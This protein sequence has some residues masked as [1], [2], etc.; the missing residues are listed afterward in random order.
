[1]LFYSS[2]CWICQTILVGLYVQSFK[3]VYILCIMW[4][5]YWEHAHILTYCSGTTA[6]AVTVGWASLRGTF[7][8]EITGFW[9]HLA[10]PGVILNNQ[11]N[12]KCVSSW[13]TGAAQDNTNTK[14]KK[15][16]K[17]SRYQ[18][19]PD[20][21][22]DIISWLLKKTVTLNIS[23]KTVVRTMFV[24]SVCCILQRL[25]SKCSACIMI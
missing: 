24:L 3:Y 8:L 11:T 5:A 4:D 17:K 19:R 15:P 7:A 1:M 21:I 14:K 2:V 9:Y 12:H 10:H 20:F 23:Q 18:D 6:A 16:Q 22:P 13:Y 25:Y